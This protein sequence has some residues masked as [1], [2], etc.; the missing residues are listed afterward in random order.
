LRLA[1]D[2]ELAGDLLSGNGTSGSLD[3]DQGALENHRK[4]LEISSAPPENNSS[5]ARHS[6]AVQEVKIAIDLTRLGEWEEALRLFDKS[7]PVFETLAASGNGMARVQ[8]AIVQG[9]I[10]DTLMMA[11]QPAAALKHYRI[12]MQL[13]R[14][15]LDKDPQN[16]SL[17]IGMAGAYGSAGFALL[18]SGRIGEGIKNLE[19][20]ER[21]VRGELAAHKENVMNR[22]TLAIAL[23][24]FAEAYRL[25]ADGNRARARA[26]EA[27]DVNQALFKEEPRDAA[28]RL[29]LAASHNLLGTLW[30]EQGNLDGARKAFQDALKL[31]EPAGGPNGKSEAAKYVLADAYSGLGG[32]ETRSDSLT[33]AQAW[34]RR[35]ASVWQTV[36]RPA[37]LSP[38]GFPTLGRAWVSAELA[39]I[40]AVLARRAHR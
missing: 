14:P 30:L 29:N 12:A 36:A 15:Q 22:S 26:L 25:S 33:E 9:R 5:L 2:Y 17:R 16:A 27:A 37:L 18:R 28:S 11:A 13:W 8:V 20:C 1:A 39:R 21:I 23:V 31:A 34:Y 19:A 35:S 7:L 40:D 32:V 10:G 24:W 6:R 38:N 4:A 3:D